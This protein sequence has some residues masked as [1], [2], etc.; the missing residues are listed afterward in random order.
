MAG[1]AEIQKRIEAVVIAALD[2]ARAH[3]YNATITNVVDPATGTRSA[4]VEV[5]PMRGTPHFD[6]LM[7][8]S[9]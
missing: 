4:K 5:Y 7:E 6:E 9:K 8:Q 3:G 2:V 1:D